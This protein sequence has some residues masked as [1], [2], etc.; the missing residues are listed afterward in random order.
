MI[1]GDSALAKTN[2]SSLK[3]GF[4]SKNR[5][6]R[7]GILNKYMF[8]IV[9]FCFVLFLE[10][11]IDGGRKKYCGRAWVLFHRLHTQAVSIFLAYHLHI[12]FI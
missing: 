3:G 5:L 12:V 6:E 7:A 10:Q 1:V 2:R 9:L 8:L 4:A 11:S